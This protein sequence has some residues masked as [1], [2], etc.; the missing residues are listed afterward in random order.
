M[1][2]GT[3]TL[4]AVENGKRYHVGLCRATLVQRLRFL[5]G[6]PCWITVDVDVWRKSLEERAKAAKEATNE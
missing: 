1:K 6:T 4:E 3:I 2:S 5:F